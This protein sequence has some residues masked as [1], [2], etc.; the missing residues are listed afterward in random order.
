MKEFLFYQD[1]KHLIPEQKPIFAP[2]ENK[3]DPSTDGSVM[4][5]SMSSTQGGFGR[6]MTKNKYKSDIGVSQ[7]KLMQRPS[8]KEFSEETLQ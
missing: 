6:K 4:N 1:K 8:L 7:P 2:S 3:E 5:Q